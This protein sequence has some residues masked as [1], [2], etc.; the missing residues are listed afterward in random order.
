MINV[1]KSILYGIVH[2]KELQAIN[3]KGGIK[4]GEE[5]VSMDYEKE[6]NVYGII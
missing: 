2:I 5:K 4:I 1:V 6:Y 3:K